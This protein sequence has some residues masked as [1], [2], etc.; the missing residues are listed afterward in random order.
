MF[1]DEHYLESRIL[2]KWRLFF[3]KR[4]KTEKREKREKRERERERGSKVQDTGEMK[5]EG[6]KRE[7]K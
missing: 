7:A 2:A 6:T 1:D 5:A 3:G 4:K